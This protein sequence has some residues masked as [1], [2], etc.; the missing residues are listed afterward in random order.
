VSA[1]CLRRGVAVLAVAVGA[2][3]VVVAFNTTRWVGATFPGF[4]LAPNRV[5]PSIALPEWADGNASRFFQDQVI[6]VDGAPVATAT[7]VYRQVRSTPPGT[8]V[9][10]TF[11][12]PGGETFTAAVA[13]RRFGGEDYAFLFGAYLFTAVAF[14]AT[15]LCVI[16]IRQTAASF[17]VLVACLATGLW[18]VTGADLY[19]PH[20]FV[21]LHL[22]AE[23]L[24]APA[25]I[26]LALVFPTTRLRT[27]RRTVLAI[28]YLVF[29]AVGI[30]YELSLFSPSAYTAVH[31]LAS[32]TH[33]IAAALV[34]VLAAVDVVRSPS[35]LVRRRVGTVAFGLLSAFLLPGAL[36]ALSA[37]RGGAVPV[38]AAA[39][40]AFLFPV[41]LGYA[42]VKE[43][44]FEL[45]VMLRRTVTYTTVIAV[46]AV[47]YFALLW[48][49]GVLVP[50]SWSPVGFALVNLLLLFAIA[51][52][53]A[54]VQLAVD[55][56]FFRQSYDG[57]A[58]LARLSERLVT[59]HT[60]GEVFSRTRTVLEQTTSPVSAA[61]YLWTGGA[62]LRD[63]AG[64]DAMLELPPALAT[65]L[66]QG[67]V[68]ARYEW[69]DGS[70]R[71]VPAVW[72]RVGA[73][74]LLPVGTSGRPM[75]LLVLGRRASGRPYSL[76]DLGFL[77][78]ATSQI[79][80]AL[81]NA[82][83]FVR[84]AELNASLER[85][86][87][88]RTASLERSLAKLRAAYDQLER[89]QASLTRAD[90]LATLGRLIAGIAHEV[91]T[92]LGAVV[93]ALKILG[94]LGREYAESIDDPAVTRDDHRQ[95]AR[96][97]IETAQAA[98]GFARKA[99]S[100][101]AR[102]RV[103]GREPGQPTGTFELA[104]LVAEIRA[105]LMHRLLA[106]S[107]RL[108]F[109]AEDPI[110]IVGDPSR[111]GQVL[112]N[113]VANAIDAYEDA[114]IADGRI[115]VRV[116]GAGRSVTITVR[117]WAGGIPPDV[118]PRIF[119]ELFTTKE[120]GRGT[121]LGLWIARNV[122]EQHF[123]GTL[124]VDVEAAVGSCFRVTLPVGEEVSARL[125]SG[126]R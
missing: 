36:T 54:H 85:Q 16:V 11:R 109:E 52:V 74:L 88:E 15:G 91:N 14:L 51:P 53:R 17:G 81:T 39:F 57:E 63:T 45:D 80:L 64:G 107:C 37:I 86:V 26:H 27:Q 38:N 112:L 29:A 75:A 68:L 34:I 123:A 103:H 25:Y 62:G 24:V 61:L 43:D 120:P 121:G 98:T 70:G 73:E 58:A 47:V 20:W 35:P 78:A 44:L 83:A 118:L 65:R 99:S 60:L 94:D 40:T 100:F 18:V 108:E 22:L 1:G 76:P 33:G 10:Y 4:F 46:I 67:E 6:A 8:P 66:E 92:P 84:L 125:A 3:V 59:A 106:T 49:L 72:D 19:G 71:P 23:T 114:G 89:N 111:L 82:D 55:R 50:R 77:R 56:L 90:R 116:A 93:S 119:D 97:L 32:G 124:D 69:D 7:Q 115:L 31:L 13:S 12:T 79:A 48:G 110:A 117:D 30:V 113:L 87:A 102:V 104:T 2:L 9:V 96:E 21:R 95:I 105:L 122:V 42:I 28:L 5:V 41:S 101:I 126:D